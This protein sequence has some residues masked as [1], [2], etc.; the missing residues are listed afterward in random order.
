MCVCVCIKEAIIYI[1][2]LK[3]TCKCTLIV[4]LEFHILQPEVLLFKETMLI[5]GLKY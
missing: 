1:D 3:F 2:I 5:V 4:L